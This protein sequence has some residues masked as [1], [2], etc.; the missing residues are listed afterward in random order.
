[1]GTFEDIALLDHYIQSI[2]KIRMQT[3]K[4]KPVFTFNDISEYVVEW[5]QI[6]LSTKFFQGVVVGAQGSGKTTTALAIAH[7]AK[8]VFEQGEPNTPVAVILISATALTMQNLER[9]REK[10][11]HK[12]VI[13]IVDDASYIFSILGRKEAG[14]Q[15]SFFSTIRHVFEG[16][17]LLLFITHVPQGIPPLMRNTSSVWVYQT[18][19][20][21]DDLVFRVNRNKLRL[22]YQLQ[23]K[24]TITLMSREYYRDPEDRVVLFFYNKQ[25]YIATVKRREIIVDDEIIE[26]VVNKQRGEPE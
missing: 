21:E 1:M 4:E 8:Q 22:F 24:H 10:H 11:L 17:M 19:M 9:L 5:A 7:A 2:S 15:K 13:F 23:R 18:V 6:V 16:K 20:N 26:Y 25:P 14:E 3:N 12:N